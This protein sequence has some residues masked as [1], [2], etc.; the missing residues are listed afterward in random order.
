ME[1]VDALVARHS[2]RISRA[3]PEGTTEAAFFER[4]VG[5]LGEQDR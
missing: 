2:E 4:V 1:P 5:M 3:V